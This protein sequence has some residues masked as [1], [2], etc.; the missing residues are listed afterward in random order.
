M[1]LGCGAQ[2][3]AVENKQGL[4]R[5]GAIRRFRG[6]LQSICI[7]TFCVNSQVGVSPLISLHPFRFQDV[8]VDMLLRVLVRVGDAPRA[9]RLV[10][11]D[12][13]GYV[14]YGVFKFQVL[15]SV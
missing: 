3:L 6:Y 8:P 1:V 7:S 11:I 13:S 10:F 15:W 2:L 12:F 14:I 4:G 5:A 9:T